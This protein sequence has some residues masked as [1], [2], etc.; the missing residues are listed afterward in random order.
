MVNNFNEFET[1]IKQSVVFS[2]VRL[3]F[4]RGNKANV[5]VKDVS[6]KIRV[7][8]PVTIGLVFLFF[9]PLLL[10]VLSAIAWVG[11]WTVSLQIDS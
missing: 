10:G 4:N 11:K 5:C 7:R 1:K 3:W 9:C 2:Y 6:G 8:F